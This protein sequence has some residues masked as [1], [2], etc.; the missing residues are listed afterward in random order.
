MK[1]TDQFFR[2]WVLNSLILI[3][4]FT[5]FGQ[6]NIIKTG[7]TGYLLGDFNLGY[8]RMTVE[9]QS[10]QFKMGYF[11]PVLSP[12]IT[13]K[14]ITPSE[15]TYLGSDGSVQMSLEYRFY[16]SKQGLKGFYLGPYFRYYGIRAEYTDIIQSKTFHVDGSVNS[17]GAGVQLGYQFI[18]NESFSLDISFFGAG[19]DK[20]NVKLLYTTDTPNFNYNDI[21]DDVSEVF[22]DVPYFEKR[23]E[24]EVNND[25]LTSKLPFIFPGLR[26]SV[27]LG[28]AF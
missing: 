14:T 17:I 24:N 21:V 7:I 11:S 1:K 5:A 16:T 2:F 13:G 26:A 20:N 9:N 3:T 28:I 27:S 10:V 6:E 22:E 19:I 12:I 25:N 18:F 4:S 8:E 23:L 15:Y